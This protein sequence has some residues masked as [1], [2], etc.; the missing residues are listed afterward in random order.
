MTPAR[1]AAAARKRLHEEHTPERIAHRIAGATEHSYLGDGVLGAIDGTVTT[2]AVVAGASGAGFAGGIALVL[3]LANVIADGFSMAV[4]NW[5]K[6]RADRDIVARA[7]RME[8]HHIEHVPDGEREEIR[9][10]FRR[11]GF[12]GE[13][14]ESIV[15]V[16]TED[17]ERWIDTM[18]T[19]ELGLPLETPEPRRAAA[20]TFAAFVLAGMMPLVPLFL[21]DRSDPARWFLI[22][23]VVTALTFLA[24]GWV[25]GS[26]VGVRAWRSSLETFLMGGGAA[27]LAWIAGTLTRGLATG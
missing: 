17:R 6:A 19:E 1:K 21:I 9:E 25:K 14:L 16:I 12:D 23:A 26:V 7:R 22:S 13:M 2:F 5:L 4:G 3:G 20:T 24:I 8:E 10:V 18:V 27:L 11:K 15:D